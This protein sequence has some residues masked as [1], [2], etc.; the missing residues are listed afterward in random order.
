MT[1]R[2]EGYVEEECECY[3]GGQDHTIPV[4]DSSHR[5]HD[6]PAVLLIG[7]SGAPP[8]VMTEEGHKE[9]VKIILMA[10]QRACLFYPGAPS[11]ISE[12][13]KAY[14]IDLT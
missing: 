3:F 4:F 2:I 9:K 12:V 14:G 11:A 10:S 6:R 1:K 7:E 5:M 13:A 8:K